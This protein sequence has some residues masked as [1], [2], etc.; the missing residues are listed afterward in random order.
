MDEVVEFHCFLRVS[1]SKNH[2]LE[3]IEQ[4]F[5]GVWE[6]LQG[7]NEDINISIEA[8]ENSVKDHDRDDLSFERGRDSNKNSS[9]QR[10]GLGGFARDAKGPDWN[11]L[12]C[13]NVNWSW[14]TTCNKCNASKPNSL[15]SKWAMKSDDD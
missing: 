9:S 13:G 6:S 3:V 2:L 7:N 5:E 4:Q 14:R 15:V 1:H 10:S 8:I 12:E 11:C